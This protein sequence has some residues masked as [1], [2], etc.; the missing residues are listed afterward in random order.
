M[1]ENRALDGWKQL[2]E[3]HP[4]EMAELKK[5]L[6][7]YPTNLRITNGKCKKL[8]GEL[9][10]YYQYDVT[11]GDRVRYQVDKKSLEVKVVYANGH[12]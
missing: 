5:F 4:A 3:A 10:D 7:Q 11:Y 6:Q 12:P 2:E 8:K 1:V 9:R